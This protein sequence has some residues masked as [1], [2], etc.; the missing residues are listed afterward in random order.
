MNCELRFKY[1]IELDEFLEN[2][3]KDRNLISYTLISKE[4]FEKDK[5][6]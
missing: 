1:K 4:T 3:K 5:D 6:F 2:L